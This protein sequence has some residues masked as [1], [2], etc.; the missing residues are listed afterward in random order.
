MLNGMLNGMLASCPSTHRCASSE[1]Y[2][3]TCLDH[4]TSNCCSVCM[5]LGKRNHYVPQRNGLFYIRRA[6]R[7]RSNTLGKNRT[8]IITAIPHQRSVRSVTRPVDLQSSQ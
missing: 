8:T 4:T 3:V 5:D 6:P 1:H 2:S 7:H